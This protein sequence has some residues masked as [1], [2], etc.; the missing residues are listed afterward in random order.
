MVLARSA[1]AGRLMGGAIFQGKEL[2]ALSLVESP[3]RVT[4]KVGRREA[5]YRLEKSAELPAA[6][7]ICDKQRFGFNAYAL[8]TAIRHA[9]V[10]PHG[11]IRRLIDSLRKQPLLHCLKPSDQQ[12]HPSRINDFTSELLTTE[13]SEQLPSP[14]EAGEHWRYCAIRPAGAKTGTVELQIRNRMIRLFT[15]KAGPRTIDVSRQYCDGTVR[16]GKEGSIEDGS[17]VNDYAFNTDC[18]WLITAP[19]GK[20][21]RLWFNQ[22]DTE[23]RTDLLYFLITQGPMKK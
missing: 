3:C 23:P 9:G 22:F 13:T 11:V 20:V 6:G 17:G 8:S 7:A 2:C 18:K 12:P 15:L 19:P 14:S 21:V 1:A 4:R 10:P 5:K 16:M